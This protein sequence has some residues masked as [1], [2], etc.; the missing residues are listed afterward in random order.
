MSSNK[1]RYQ[2]R[3]FYDQVGWKKSGPQQYQNALFE[4]LRPVSSEY[5]H[6]CHLRVNHFLNPKG[7]FF[8]DAGSG[9]IQYPEYLSYS[10][11][12]RFRVCLDISL[13]A[14]VE[15][16]KKIKGHGLYVLADVTNLPFCSD[17]FD[18]IISLHTLHHLTIGEQL[19]AYHEILRVLKKD[20]RAVVVNGWKTSPLMQHLDRLMALMERVSHKTAHVKEKSGNNP[21]PLQKPQG[22]FVDEMNASYL[23][24]K[25]DGQVP[26]EIRVWRSVNVRFL[27]TLIHPWSGGKIWLKIIYW[28]EE[29]FPHYLGEN[30]AYPLIIIKKSW[31]KDINK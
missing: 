8:L 9:P 27:R 22:T 10:A 16:R 23:K 20:A 11:G 31:A 26:L 1:T 21:Q 30:G 18:G 4:D 12:Y 7:N 13:T 14:L 5:I 6:R 15:A 29:R 28:L 24:A 17:T 19:K 3:Q 2:V 25:L